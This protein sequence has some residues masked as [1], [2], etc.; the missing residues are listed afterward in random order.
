M[1]SSLRQNY[2]ICMRKLTYFVVL[3]LPIV[4]FLL[5]FLLNHDQLLSYDWDYFSQLYEGARISILEY[6][7]FPWINP[8]VA[9]G[10][11]LYANPQFGLISIQMPLVLAFGTLLG[12]KLSA[13]FFF[14]CGFWGM[15]NLLQRLGADSIIA[16]TLSYIWIFSGFTAWHLQIGHITF[17]SYFLAPW[18]FVSLLNIRKK[19]G[20]LWC[21][22]IFAI[23][24][25]QS[26]HYIAVQIILIAIPVFIY[27][28]INHR[29]KYNLAFWSLLKPYVLAL[30]VA[31]PLVSHKLYFTLQYL[32]D[33]PRTPPPEV[34]TPFNLIVAGLTFRGADGLDPNLSFNMN[35]FWAEYSVYFGLLTIGVF[36]FLLLGKLQSKKQMDT[37]QWFLLIGMA[38]VFL[39]ALGNFSQFSP[40][41]ILKEL[42]VFN[43]MQ[44]PARWLGWL[45]IG[46]ILFLANLKR[47]KALILILSLSALDVFLSSFPIIN[48]GAPVYQPPSQYNSIIQQQAFYKNS[49]EFSPKTLRLLHATQSNTGDIYGYEPLV[50]FA[51][52]YND[53]YREASNRCD[54]R[55]ASC[56]FVLT[57]N[58]VV[59]YWS[60]NYIKL[61]RTGTGPI[62]ININPGSYWKVNGIRVFAEMDVIELKQNFVITNEANEININADP[63]H[64]P[65]L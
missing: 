28:L 35:L 6:K 45:V 57:N 30:A 33:F 8:W 41:A 65:M 29:N 15:R 24:I 42:P 51:G 14:I 59:E 44:A 5:P 62:E 47:N 16:L 2:F 25:N 27:Q 11:P 31:I 18:F 46:V 63:K 1:N 22:L 58:A 55:M 48:Q 36:A 32:H 3:S 23:L 52:I 7:Q 13:L 43:Q 50:G 26:I 61:R 12:L 60:P 17:L 64:M 9:G 21:G 56:S 39:L 19:F 49:S 4:V 37:K 40:Y 54:T 38:L 10:V 53:G 34:A 20:W